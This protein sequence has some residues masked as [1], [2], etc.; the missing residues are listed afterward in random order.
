MINLLE[1]YVYRL[2]SVMDIPGYQGFIL[3]DDISYGPDDAVI[4]LG[5]RRILNLHCK[6]AYLIL[7]NN[8]AIRIE[9]FS[10]KNN[11][12]SNMLAEMGIKAKTKAGYSKGKNA[13]HYAICKGPNC[14]MRGIFSKYG[15]AVQE[16]IWADCWEYNFKMHLFNPGWVKIGG[17]DADWFCTSNW[18]LDDV[19]DKGSDLIRK[20]LIEPVDISEEKFRKAL[21]KAGLEENLLMGW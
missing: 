16:R 21:K 13:W 5:L 1:G 9:E 14:S 19:I 7:V 3:K 12:L 15:Y 2:G 18:V 6:K 11:K 4:D 20:A 10:G 17:V 8:N